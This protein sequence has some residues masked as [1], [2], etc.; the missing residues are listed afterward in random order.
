MKKT[1][2]FLSIILTLASCKEEPAPVVEEN[3]PVIELTVG[4]FQNFGGVS[5][6]GSLVSKLIV[7]NRTGEIVEIDRSKF[8]SPFQV[9]SYEGQCNLNEIYGEQCTFFIK[10]APN[11]EGSFSSTLSVRGYSKTFN[12][13]GL[14]SNKLSI[15]TSSWT[16]GSVEAGSVTKKS[17]ILENRGDNY[18]SLPTIQG[19]SDFTLSYTTCPQNIA[20]KSTCLYEISYQKTTSGIFAVTIDLVTEEGA[21]IP[22]FTQSEIYPSTPAGLISIQGWPSLLESDG[23]TEYNLTASILDEYGNLVSDGRLVSIAVENVSLIGSSTRATQNGQ[24]SFSLKASTTKG[25][26]SVTIL[27]DQAS[28]YLRS[29]TKS[30]L[31]YGNIE[32]GAFNPNIRVGG[33]TTLTL[34][35]LPV[36]DESGEVVDDGTLVLAEL[37]GGGELVNSVAPTRD[38]V[39]FFSVRSGTHAE[40]VQVNLFANP[41][42]D[43][44]GGISYLASGSYNI[45]YIPTLPYGNTPITPES[46]TIYFSR[47]EDSSLA[48]HTIIEVGPVLGEHGNNVGAGEKV[49]ITITNGVNDL[50]ANIFSIYTEADGIARFTL[51]SIGIRG[52]IVIE[53]VINSYISFGQV[54]AVSPQSINFPSVTAKVYKASGHSEM[55]PESLSPSSSNWVEETH[56]LES[57]TEVDGNEFGYKMFSVG[58][59]TLD[60]NIPYLLMDCLFPVGK[61]FIL[62]PCYSSTVEDSQVYF[63]GTDLYTFNLL[64]NLGIR[65]SQNYDTHF[66]SENGHA[67]YRVAGVNTFYH[68]KSEKLYF[69]GGIDLSSSATSINKLS[70]YSF[71]IGLETSFDDLNFTSEIKT[72]ATRPFSS[73]TKDENYV[74][75]FGGFTIQSSEIVLSRDISFLSLNDQ[76]SLDS[77][78]IEVEGEEEDMISPR[79]LSAITKIDDEIYIVGGLGKDDGELNFK[80]EVWKISTEEKLWTLVCSSCGLPDFFNYDPILLSP[81]LTGSIN[82]SDLLA[83]DESLN[84]SRIVFDKKRGKHY[85]YYERSANV[86]EIDLSSGQTAPALELASMKDLGS[87]KVNSLT[88]HIVGLKNGDSRGENSKLYFFDEGPERKQYYRVSY[89]LPEDS[90]D[91][92]HSFQIDYTGF[93]K[94]ETLGN[95]GY[96]SQVGMAIYM[97]NSEL[98]VW[99]IADSSDSANSIEA[100]SNERSIQRTGNSNFNQYIDQQDQ[101]HLLITPAHA[102]GRQYGQEGREGRSDLKLNSLKLKGQW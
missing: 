88:G 9:Y 100:K 27:S 31:P 54:Y 92:A 51:E 10:F 5:L 56:N 67:H 73:I 63:G 13:I 19:S 2:L 49:D 85:F 44:N 78:E 40:T 60:T 36:V 26:S 59:K 33:E 25:F 72:S 84:E 22:I 6:G 95:S 62:P 38:G 93:A 80:D 69:L 17:F 61:F 70:S 102:P 76:G 14:A 3:L 90:K 43:G 32:V 52:P 74:Y 21:T 53:S 42:D 98:D 64:E 96:T 4:G 41:S 86:Y 35:T 30:G 66:L 16:I 11:S 34:A 58:V 55:N 8:S 89:Q 18:L 82:N 12:G 75:S 48:A 99:E 24:I 79:I 20:P 87:L 65:E 46:E 7:K 1:F 91:L 39:A 77:E 83:L 81:L 50:G 94:S 29:K 37:I 68:P 45:T 71:P 47:G 23:V 101:L 15:N 57:M 28:G 97:W